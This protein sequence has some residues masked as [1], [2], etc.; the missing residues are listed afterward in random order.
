[1]CW[2][3]HAQN[4]G[5][6]HTPIGGTGNDL[7][8]DNSSQLFGSCLPLPVDQLTP[9]VLPGDHPARNIPNLGVALFN[10]CTAGLFAHV[11]AA[12]VENHSRVLTGDGGSQC[13]QLVVRDVGVGIDY[14]ARV[15]NVY[16]DG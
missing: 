12:A 15:R 6:R 8:K 4:R 13:V 1:M 7:P 14:F 5:V 16:V 3:R 9:A 11:A 10:E 2:Y